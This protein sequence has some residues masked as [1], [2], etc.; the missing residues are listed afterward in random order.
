MLKIIQKYGGIVMDFGTVSTLITSVGFPIVACIG[1]GWYV[2]AQTDAYR[3]DVKDMRKEYKEDI[4][5]VTEALN[6]NTLAIQRLVDK[7]DLDDDKK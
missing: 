7:L 5:S 1:M 3:D 6:N 2:K 4:K